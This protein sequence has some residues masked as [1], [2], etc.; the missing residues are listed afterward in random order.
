MLLSPAQGLAQHL[1]GLV[2]VEVTSPQE[3]EDVLI[4]GNL[5][6]EGE[7]PW[8]GIP[9]PVDKIM[10]N[11]FPALSAK[12]LAGKRTVRLTMT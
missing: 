2:Q 1:P 11:E 7:S 12:Y 10:E 6:K 9:N 8:N 5:R 4:F 3:P